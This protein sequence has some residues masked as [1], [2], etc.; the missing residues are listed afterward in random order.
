MSINLPFMKTQ[1][2]KLPII[3]HDRYNI[4][5]T[6]AIQVYGLE[7]KLSDELCNAVTSSEDNALIQ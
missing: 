4:D 6:I 7:S 2:Q 5:M 3:P 1:T